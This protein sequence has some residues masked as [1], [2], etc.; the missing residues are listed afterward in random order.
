[1]RSTIMF[2]FLCLLGLSGSANAANAQAPCQSAHCQYLPL[3]HNPAP[4]RITVVTEGPVFAPPPHRVIGEVVATGD[5]PVYGVVIEATMYYG[6]D[7][8]LISTSLGTTLF[9]ATL[10][11]QVNPIDF[12]IYNVSSLYH[13]KSARIITWTLESE[14][15][16]IELTTVM[17]ITQIDFGHG[18]YVD[19]Q[20]RNDSGL[21]VENVQAVVWAMGESYNNWLHPVADGLAPGESAYYSDYVANI[22]Y[23]PEERIQA[24]AQGVIAAP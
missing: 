18:T 4:V 19:V 10:P 14:L 15:E 20:V 13:F 16:Y 23:K 24:L 22:F 8:S 7:P 3:M 2:F 17:T 1:M 12:Y 6:P 11:G 21:P 9:T 5:I